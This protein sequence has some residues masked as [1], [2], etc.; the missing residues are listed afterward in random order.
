VI[1][2]TCLDVDHPGFGDRSRNFFQLIDGRT[3]TA[4]NKPSC[5]PGRCGHARLESAAD[6]A[7]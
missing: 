3:Q 6:Q 4:T 7:S 2:L 1:I 5:L